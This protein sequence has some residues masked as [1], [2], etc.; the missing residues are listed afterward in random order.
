V[1]GL[2]LL[3]MTDDSDVTR[4]FLQDGLGSTTG[5]TDEAGAV[6]DRYEYDV[7]GA[8]RTHVGSS[9][10][11]WLFTGEQNDAGVAGSPYYLRAR[12]YDPGIGRFLS[13]DRWPGNVTDPQ[14]LNDYV[15]TLNNPARFTD[16]YG[17]W[18][19]LGDIKHKA[20]EVAGAVVDTCSSAAKATGAWLST[21]NWG[22]IAAGTAVIAGG[23]AVAFTGGYV[24]M[25]AAASASVATSGLGLYEGLHVLTLGGT[26]GVAGGGITGMGM[27]SMTKVGCGQGQHRSQVL[28]SMRSPGGRGD[29]GDGKE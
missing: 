4:Y 26:M 27:F 21:C 7:F 9:S 24:A 14:T 18:P 28:G 3:S 25:G 12:Y 11:S 5:L 23:A 15:Y 6:T 20:G 8:T 29:Y 1:Y 10:N 17:Y 22:K 2:D 19:S 16:P 13:Q